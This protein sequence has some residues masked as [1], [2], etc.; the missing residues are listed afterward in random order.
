MNK[1][2]LG[3][4]GSLLVVA[5]LALPMSAAYATKP[6]KMFLHEVSEGPVE[7]MYIKSLAHGTLVF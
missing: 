1:K 2:I 4:F 3:V 6:E 7:G 5:I